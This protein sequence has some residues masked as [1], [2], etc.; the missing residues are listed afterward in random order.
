MTT[1][2][3]VLITSCADG[4]GLRIAVT[5]AAAGWRVFATMPDPSRAGALR[6]ALA[7]AGVDAT[8]LQLDPEDDASVTRAVTLAMQATGNRLDAV[9]TV[10]GETPLGFFEDLTAAQVRHTLDGVLFGAMAVVRAALP[11]MRRRRQGKI[12]TISSHAALT[13]SPTLSALAAAT[14]ALEGWSEALA[15]EV[16]PFGL[17]VTVLQPSLE[18]SLTGGTQLRRDSGYR[19][20]VD[21]AEPRVRASARYEASAE[22]E[23]A[24]AVLATLADPTPPLRLPVGRQARSATWRRRLLP[25]RGL[26]DGVA[27]ATGLT[28]PAPESGADRRWRRRLG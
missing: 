26:A 1:R 10:P 27:R 5:A 17:S 3:S 20:L 9:V 24:D 7:T 8:V 13:P 28:G 11:T 21:R 4:L 15:L 14:W 2:G 18:G 23:V 16:A 12:I 6:S 19:L 25:F 22:H